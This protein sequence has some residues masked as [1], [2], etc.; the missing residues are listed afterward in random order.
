VPP[1]QP[2]NGCSE[3]GRG[4][5]NRIVFE[6]ELETFIH[7]HV[8]SPIHLL[9]IF[10]PFLVATSRCRIWLPLLVAVLQA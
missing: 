7:P 10:L 5:S 8:H 2:L 9:F 1:N 3:I 4:E 6:R